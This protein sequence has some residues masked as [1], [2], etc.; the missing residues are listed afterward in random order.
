ML[1]CDFHIHTNWSDG[2]HHL[3]DIVDAYGQEGFRA[4]AITD[5]LCEDKTFLGKAAHLLNRSLRKENFSD[6][7]EA[8]AEEASRA[9]RLYNMTLIPGVEITKNSFQHADSA[10]IVAL[11]VNQY[12]DPN[13]DILNL[14]TSLKDQGAVTV[15]AHPVSTRKL[16]AQ[17]YFLWN[18]RHDLAPYF[19]AWE[20][21]SGPVLFDEV[22]QSRL[23][24]LANSDLHHLSQMRAWKTLVQAENSEGAILDSIRKQNIDFIF[25]QGARHANRNRHRTSAQAV[26]S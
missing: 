21:A 2:H 23:P 14:L 17:T 16:E 25:H 26:F 5:H 20:V 15:A 22:S 8:I 9:K 6:Y 4:I 19:D 18:H 1:L 13:Q 10:H 24:L 7:L 11:G 12:V 3:R